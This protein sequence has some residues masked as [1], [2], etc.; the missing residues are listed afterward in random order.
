MGDIKLRS[1]LSKNVHLSR[2]FSHFNSLSI[3]KSACV[4]DFW[5]GSDDQIIIFSSLKGGET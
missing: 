2:D 5:F 4:N 3:R 1:R